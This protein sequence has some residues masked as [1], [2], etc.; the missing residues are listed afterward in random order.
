MQF[1]VSDPGQPR[2]VDYV[3]TGLSNGTA[4]PEGL[5][6]IPSW[7]SPDGRTFVVVAYEGKGGLEVFA[8]VPEPTSLWLL[9]LGAAGV[10]MI[11]R[12]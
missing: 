8:V 5:F 10:W 12:R 1:D 4:A 9:V 3:N 2:F 11:R 7:M 6:F